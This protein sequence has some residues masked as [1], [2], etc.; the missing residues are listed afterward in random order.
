[1]TLSS[2]CDHGVLITLDWGT[3]NVRAALLDDTGHV[4]EERRGESG[5]GHYDKTDFENRFD[6]LI[7]GWPV[8]PAM[9]AGMVGSRQGWSE[10]AYLP[11][12]V[13]INDLAEGLHEISHGGRQ[14]T[15]VPGVKL[16][17]GSRC[18]VMRGEESQL[19][20]FLAAHST[21]S[22]TVIM[23]GTHSKWVSVE[24]QTIGNFYTYMTGDLFEALSQHSILR[25]SVCGSDGTLEQFTRK[26]R[27]LANVTTSIEGEYFGFRARHLLTGCSPDKLHQE[28]SALLIMA[29]L[30]AGQA[31][32]F[33]LDDEVLIVGSEGLNQLYEIA[34][35]AIGKRTKSV[36]GTSLV[37]PALYAIARRANII[38]GVN[39]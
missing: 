38:T 3:T 5:V 14:I 22:G 20:G 23:P 11:C 12:P 36:R 7:K 39:A 34:L 30:R 17:D 10:A 1:M 8:V 6:Q 9:A 27:E 21:F 31:D 19:A 28:L 18:D 25:H 32:G 35:D 15:I 29:E 2:K 24:Q 4:L 37:W 26:A 16:D 13:S 33:R